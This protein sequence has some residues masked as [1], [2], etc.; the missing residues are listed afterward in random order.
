MPK[1]PDDFPTQAE[2]DRWWEAAALANDLRWMIG[3]VA[4]GC[5]LQGW[6]AGRKRSRGLAAAERA[7]EDR[8]LGEALGAETR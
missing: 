2:V 4:L 3:W 8:L 6:I 7:E 1:T 5:M